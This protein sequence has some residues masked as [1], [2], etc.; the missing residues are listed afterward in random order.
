MHYHHSHSKKIAFVA[1]IAF[2]GL[3][4]QSGLTKSGSHASRSM[5]PRLHDQQDPAPLLTNNYKVTN[6]VS[7]LPGFAQ[8][9]DKL[10][11]NPW[12]VT[13]SATSPFWVANNATS[14]ATLY[15][16]D[17]GGSP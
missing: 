15:G 2:L 9:Q 16:G 1:F 5:P 11:V 13:M 3:L 17:V 6:L 12:G 7:D 10:L 4:S 8:I 14:T